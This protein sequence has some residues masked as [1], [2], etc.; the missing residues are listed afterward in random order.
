MTPLLHLQRRPGGR[1][2]HLADALLRLGRTL[3]VA[4]RVN[5]LRHGASL[6][7]FHWLLLH[8]LQFLDR[9]GV[10]SQILLVSH[11]DD[12]H[13]GTEVTHLGGPLLGDV[14]ETVGTVDGETHEDDVGVGVG[15]RTQTVV[16]LLTGRVPQR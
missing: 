8:L 3:E 14:L 9:V 10:V 4:E 15:E 13:V 6:L 5:L 2:E 11:Q 1:L 16:V 12:R 7:V